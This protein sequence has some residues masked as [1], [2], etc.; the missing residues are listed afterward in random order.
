MTMKRPDIEDIKA[1]CEKATPGHWEWW[2]INGETE[3]ALSDQPRARKLGDSVEQLSAFNE[4]DLRDPDCQ[5]PRCVDI[6]DVEYYTTAPGSHEFLGPYSKD[7]VPRSHTIRAAAI[8]VSSEDDLRFV[9][10][11][12]KDIPALLAYVEELEAKLKGGGR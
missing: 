1:R 8:R 9:A 6:L 4:E 11:A 10:N 3:W 12:R 2:D 7:K 5:E